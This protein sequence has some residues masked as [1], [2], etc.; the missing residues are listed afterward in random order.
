MPAELVI[1]I[2]IL[3]LI[4][5]IPTIL[6]PRFEQIG[7]LF[8]FGILIFLIIFSIQDKKL[9]KQKENNFLKQDDSWFKSKYKLSK[10]IP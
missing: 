6:F 1:K 9:K 5:L 2:I 10:E 3:I 4:L 7:L 8:I